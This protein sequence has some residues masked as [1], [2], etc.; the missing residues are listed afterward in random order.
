MDEKS[1]W[2]CDILS[3]DKMSHPQNA[4]ATIY[5]APVFARLMANTISYKKSGMDNAEPLY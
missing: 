2:E 3:R 4:G 5:R 1:A